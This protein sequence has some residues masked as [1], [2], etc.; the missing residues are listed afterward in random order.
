MGYFFDKN[1]SYYEGDRVHVEDIEVATKLSCDYIWNGSAEVLDTAKLAADKAAKLA[2]Y[3]TL[4]DTALARLS[5]IQIDSTVQ[6]DIDAIKVAKQSLKDMTQHASVVAAVGGDAT[7]EA[8][9]ALYFA[10]S[11]QLFQSAP[12][13]YAEFRALDV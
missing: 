11:A 6:S 13:V 2:E 3:I 5:N 10:A 1:G 9:Q 12:N 8:L 4:R 7:E